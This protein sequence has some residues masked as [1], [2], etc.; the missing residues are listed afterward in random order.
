MIPATTV[1]AAGHC[2]HGCQRNVVFD[3]H[4][5]LWVH[6]PWRVSALEVPYWH[7]ATPWSP[8]SEAKL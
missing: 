4:R 5:D 7:H 6:M 2:R 8:D 1:I 3:Q